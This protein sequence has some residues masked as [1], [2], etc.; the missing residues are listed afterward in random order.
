MSGPNPN[1]APDHGPSLSAE[2]DGILEQ[3]E[4]YALGALD[5]ADSGIVE[6]HLRWCPQ[7]RGEEEA[8]RRAV[9]LLP[10]IVP[11]AD[12]PSPAVK[13]LLFD[14]IAADESQ[15]DREDMADRLRHHEPEVM[16][17]ARAVSSVTPS[18]PRTPGSRTSNP[19]W[20]RFVP[21]A[22]IAPLAIALLVVGAWANSMRLDL[23][24][25][26]QGQAIANQGA[27]DQIVANGG[28]VQLYSMEP[29]CVDCT[30]RGR[31]GV[32]VADRL[33]VVVAW[34]LN[35]DREHELWCF[36]K[37]GDKK[38]VAKLDV[39]AEG[40]AMQAFSFPSDM[41][42]YSGVYVAQTDGEATY[43]SE[44]SPD[45]TEDSSATPAR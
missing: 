37:K 8:I 40:G 21:P 34:G 13:G 41:T 12:V 22:V 28:D 33:G 38:M 27:L 26:D 5:R 16:A 9:D 6:Q 1:Q 2:H 29:Q 19:A 32:D 25:R 20:S 3:L 35:P 31:I 10:F 7:C 23:E 24:E 15:P 11:P 36:N 14:R 43:M 4:A 45:G 17:G 39:D 44:F 30:G 18:A 42:D